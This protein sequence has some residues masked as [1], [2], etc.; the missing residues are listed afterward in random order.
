MNVLYGQKNTDCNQYYIFGD[1]INTLNYVCANGEVK[2]W[3]IGNHDDHFI[4]LCV[5]TVKNNSVSKN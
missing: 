4:Y 1:Q 2:L 3:S 5:H